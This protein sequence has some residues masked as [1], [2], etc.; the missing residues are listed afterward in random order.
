MFFNEISGVATRFQF[1]PNSE[2]GAVEKNHEGHKP[3]SGLGWQATQ[4]AHRK[5]ICE[6]IW[7]ILFAYFLFFNSGL[8]PEQRKEMRLQKGRRASL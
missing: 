8:I 1:P 7:A 6:W 5:E 4:L 2:E 3:T